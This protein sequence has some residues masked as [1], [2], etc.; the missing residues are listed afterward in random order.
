V[1]NSLAVPPLVLATE[2]FQKEAT[3]TSHLFIHSSLFF[4]TSSSEFSGQFTNQSIK[5]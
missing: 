2:D 1:R 3:T 4:I 5:A